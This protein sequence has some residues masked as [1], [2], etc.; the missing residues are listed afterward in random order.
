MEPVDGAGRW[1]REM[2][3][4]EIFRLHTVMNRGMGWEFDFWVTSTPEGEG[5][6]VTRTA[7]VVKSPHLHAANASLN[8]FGRVDV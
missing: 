2:E 7:K 4:G 6:M 8:A 1:S 5:T 3:P